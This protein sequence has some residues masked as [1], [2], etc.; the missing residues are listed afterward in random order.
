[1]RSCTE[2]QAALPSRVA[3]RREVLLLARNLGLAAVPALRGLVTL[4]NDRQAMINGT[5]PPRLPAPLG[6]T[7]RRRLA[8]WTPE[9]GPGIVAL[10]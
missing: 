5:S 8:V 1:M 2:P 7:F 9:A 6:L 3:G 10:L 4:S